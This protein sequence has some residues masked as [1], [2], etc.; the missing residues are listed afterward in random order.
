LT[1]GKQM[2]INSIITKRN[3]LVQS[4]YALSVSETRV[5]LL[6]LSKIDSSKPL[7]L[8]QEFTITANDFHGELGLDAAN[9]YR[10]LRAAVDKLWKREILIDP[11]DPGSMVR[12]ISKKAYFTS[13]GSVN[14]A[15]SAQLMPYITE[16]RSRFTSY[17][18]RD[19]AKFKNSYSIRIYEL[20]VQFKNNH[21]RRISVLDFRDMLDL[22]EKYSTIKDLKKRIVMPALDDIN[23]HSNV[24]AELSQEKQ[25]KEITH[26]IF[27]YSVKKEAENPKP[28]TNGTKQLI[29]DF[30]GH[31]TYPV[32]SEVVM[33]EL[34]KLK[35]KPEPKPKKTLDS[36]K[37]SKITG[38]KR[39][40]THG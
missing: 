17:K 23:E 7:P 6:C 35:T 19:V 10:D 39:A 30:H 9:A 5:I 29:P 13:K 33:Q 16:L 27:K 20:L 37:K 12:W 28:K 34:E 31:P 8:D 22:G 18:L 4:S 21:E 3:D 26:L 32:D 2:A 15:F 40:V 36:D 25:G 38:L 11:S 1:T 14:I 24:K